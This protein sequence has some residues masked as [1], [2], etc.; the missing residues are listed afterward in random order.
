MS[1][2]VSTFV[3][4]FEKLGSDDV[5]RA[6]GKGANLGEMTRAELPVPPGFVVTA[7]AY[8]QFLDANDLKERIAAQLRDLNPS[9]SNDLGVACEEIQRWIIEASVPDEIVAIIRDAYAQLSSRGKTDAEFVAVL[10]SAT[11]EDTKAASFAGMNR[12][13]TNVRGADE[14]FT[15]VRECWASLYGERVI[16][17][18]AG[19]QMKDEPAIAVVV[20]KMVNSD[21]AGVMFTAD[22]ATGDGS[23]IV[24]E[25]AWGL[26]DVVVGGQVS[27]DHLVVN[28][29]TG[30]ITERRIGHKTFKLVR[31]D[32]GVDSRVELDKTEAYAPVL[33]DDEIARLVQMARRNEEHYEQPQDIEWAIEGQEV[34]IVQSRPITVAAA[35]RAAEAKT[36]DK[37]ARGDG[38][39]TQPRGRELVKGLGASAGIAVGAAH[40]QHSADQSGGFKEGEVLVAPM[41]APDWMSLMQKASAIVTEQGGATSHAAI[42]SREMGLPCVVGA[43]K[44]TNLLKDA[45]TVTVDGGSGVIYEGR[46]YQR[47]R[48]G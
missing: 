45:M 25:A 48:A 12:S 41:T 32:K 36:P 46:R 11:A 5:A 23:V 47:C 33:T 39:S 28:K 43:D 24:I 35:G 22:P 19:K 42:V 37:A 17:Y 21:K 2:K 27:P 9:E 26:G 13:F 3:S 29:E 34:L 6:G 40:V 1:D 44:A 4:W 8:Q 30:G 7:D 18:R 14:L 20:Q 15:R 16:I 38:Q 10:S 31:G